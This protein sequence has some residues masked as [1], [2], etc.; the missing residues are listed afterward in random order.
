MSDEPLPGPSGIGRDVIEGDSDTNSYQ[1]AV[2][3]K[4]KRRKVAKPSEWKANVAKR[5]RNSGKEYVSE[6]TGKTVA[7]RKVGAPCTCKAK[8]IYIFSV[9]SL[10]SS[11]QSS[12]ICGSLF[13]LAFA[14]VA[15]GHFRCVSF[16]LIPLYSLLLVLVRDCKANTGEGEGGV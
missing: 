2:Q 13:S 12:G 1:E 3:G 15:F 14:I 4:V 6:R 8:I 9:I 10:P 11:F 7:A 5:K 16:S